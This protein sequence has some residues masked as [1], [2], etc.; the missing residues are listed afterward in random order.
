MPDPTPTDLP[1]LERAVMAEARCVREQRGD[2]DQG[3]CNGMFTK[4]PECALA[5]LTA[6]GIHLVTEGQAVLQGRVV[7][8]EFDAHE[9]NGPLTRD[10]YHTPWMRPSDDRPKQHT[11]SEEE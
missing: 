3:S 6:A 11:D 1:P 7:E 4:H 10:R 8:M 2:L 5:A 9:V